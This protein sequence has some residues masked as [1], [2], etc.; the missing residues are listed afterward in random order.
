MWQQDLHCASAV[1][2]AN[3]SGRSSSGPPSRPAQACVQQPRPA[4]GARRRERPRLGVR[5][6]GVGRAMVAWR[7]GTGSRPYAAS[8]RMSSGFSNRLCDTSLPP[9]LH[10]QF[11]HRRRLRACNGA[12]PIVVG[13]VGSFL[14]LCSIVYCLLIGFCSYEMCTAPASSTSPGASNNG[15]GGISTG[16]FFC[17]TSEGEHSNDQSHEV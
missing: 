7:P 14:R 5:H 4:H 8:S 15:G 17:M 6:R 3:S 13:A 2:A 10:R 16:T 11:P 1:A 12:C 9:P